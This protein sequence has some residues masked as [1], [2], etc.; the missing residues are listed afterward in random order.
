MRTCEGIAEP[1]GPLQ[2][3]VVVAAEDED[4][5]FVDLEGGAEAQQFQRGHSSGAFDVDDNP[6]VASHRVPASHRGYI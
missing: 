4:V 3:A 6:A 5:S 1:F 2:L